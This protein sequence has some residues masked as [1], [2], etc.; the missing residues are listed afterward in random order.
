MLLA[1]IPSPDRGVWYLGP[2]PIRA[3]ALFIIIGIIVA[4]WWG[5]R[6]F[7]AR[8]GQPGVVIDVAVF[9]VPFG[10][11]GG[12]LYHVLTDWSTYFAEGKNPVDALK[13]WEGGLGIWGAITLGG[14][15]AW[16]GCRRRGV[17][18]PFLADAA[19]PGIVV[20]QA[21][22][23]IGNWF[24]QELY[25]RDT[26]LPWGLEIYQRIDPDTGQPDML[27]GITE[28]QVPLQ[29][30]HPTFLYELLWNLGVA[31]LVVWA[32]RRFRLGHGRAFAVYVAGY[33][34]GRFWIELLRSD[35][36]TMV[37]GV[38]INVITS[39][40]VFAG[41][42]AYI[43]LA[44]KGREKFAP[45]DGEPT[46]PAESTG[47]PEST[48]AGGAGAQPTAS[49]PAETTTP[50]E[51]TPAEATPAEATPAEATPA[52]A[53]PDEAT[54]AE[55]K[56]AEAEPAEAESAEAEA[57]DKPAETERPAA[58]PAESDSGAAAGEGRP[59]GGAAKGS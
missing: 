49:E 19:A 5:E 27:R 26:T 36:A 20:A 24:N 18:L 10:L 7:V 53:T 4:I 39:V 32:D 30:V 33:T 6:R 38:R 55:A 45:A 42:V 21:I 31:A 35:P 37:F 54:P 12:R 28:S 17:P 29:I 25:G 41:A 11:I 2:V 59:A 50:A 58:K 3:Y 51:A 48:E 47:P 14:V 8:G 1:S 40:V 56:P 46:E 13:I 15:G 43:L 44:P 16:I 22:G 34:A 23:R 52:E 57:A 9:A